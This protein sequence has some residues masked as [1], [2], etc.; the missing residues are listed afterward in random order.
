MNEA[1]KA[2]WHLWVLGIVSL[3]WFAGGANDYYQTK[4]GNMDYLGM[5]AEGSGIPLD[6]MVDYF[7]A[8]PTWATI[9]WALGVWGAV[10]GSLLLLFRSRFAI[11]GYIASVVGLI[12]SMAY[13]L[14]A[15]MP[16]AMNSAG[17]WIFTAVIWLS[18]IG[19]AYYAKRMTA[20]GVLR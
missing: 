3:I 12:V 19:M 6:V 8:Y 15:D 10:A 2:P 18:L 9:A 13:T 4:T 17:M 7:A 5:A 20:A 1:T 16:A 14:T 11:F